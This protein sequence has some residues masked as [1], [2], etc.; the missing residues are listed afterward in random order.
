MFFGLKSTFN[1]C[2][3]NDRKLIQTP[4]SQKLIKLL[5]EAIEKN[6]EEE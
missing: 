4:K 2:L 5:L 3:E 1:T 6:G